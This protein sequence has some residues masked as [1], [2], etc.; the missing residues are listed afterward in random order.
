[1]RARAAQ[2]TT[3][4]RAQGLSELSRATPCS[5]QGR[6]ARAPFP[7]GLVLFFFACSPSPSHPKKSSGPCAY[8]CGSLGGGGHA[9]PHALDKSSR[10]LG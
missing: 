1:M 9:P 3:R 8:V 4:R 5:G 2:T 10:L 6:A 7:S